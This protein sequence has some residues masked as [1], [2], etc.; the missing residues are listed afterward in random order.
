MTLISTPGKIILLGEDI[1]FNGRSAIAIAI[2]LRLR[3][4]IKPAELYI[5]DGYKMTGSR[6]PYTMKAI[7]RLWEA[8]TPIEF[9]INSKIPSGLGLGSS[10]A[11][12]V[13]TVT[14]LTE[15]KEDITPAWIARE[16]YEIEAAV[17]GHAN[18]LDATIV[19]NG[20]AVTTEE[21]PSDK[22]ALWRIH[23]EDRDWHFEEAEV[24]DIIIVIGMLNRKT[25]STDILD[26]VQRFKD[27]SGFAKDILKELGGLTK[28]ALPV[29][30]DQDLNKF[31]VLMDKSHKLLN[32]LGMNTPQMQKIVEAARRY[33]YG[34]KISASSG[35]NCMYALT[36]KPDDAAEA[37]KSA[38]GTPLITKLTR[39]GVRVV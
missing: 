1:L 15:G 23:T 19:A 7:E 35:G 16:S 24:P 39:A 6:H 36:D 28:K 29:L 10:T 27:K 13:A 12:T 8:D 32:I 3:L 20:S 17:K 11:L 21:K 5:V 33:S 31:G 18:P 2:D 37:I 38:G 4:E 26:K 14:A 9:T 25:R 34:A 22:P 30:K